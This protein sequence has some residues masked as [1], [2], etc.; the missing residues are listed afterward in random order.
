MRRLGDT[1]QQ[2]SSFNK[3]VKDY[4]LNNFIYFQITAQNQA[5]A[6]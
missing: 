2:T 1:H 3:H 4:I 6:F 5:I